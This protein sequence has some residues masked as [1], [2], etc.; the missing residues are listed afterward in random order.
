MIPYMHISVPANL[1]H[2]LVRQLTIS[3]ST[4]NKNTTLYRLLNLGSLW[5]P[6]TE[7]LRVCQW[8]KVPQT[9]LQI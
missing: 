7:H 5:T 4:S 6:T 3:N 1:N 9:P 2:H 8:K